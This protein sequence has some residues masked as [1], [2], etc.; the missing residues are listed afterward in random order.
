MKK[1][2]V[3]V[4]L[5]LLI[6]IVGFSEKRGKARRLFRT[7]IVLAG[8]AAGGDFTVVFPKPMPSADYTFICQAQDPSRSIGGIEVIRA[9]VSY[10]ESITLWVRNTANEIRVGTIHCIAWED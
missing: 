3:V 7:E 1:L 8:N 9:G 4:L 10:P 2:V 6:P 5:L